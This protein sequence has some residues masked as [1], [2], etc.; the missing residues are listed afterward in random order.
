MVVR[1]EGRLPRFVDEV[2]RV[3]LEVL[4]AVALAVALSEVVEEVRDEVRVAVRDWDWLV[5]ELVDEVV[6]VVVG[7]GVRVS[8]ALRE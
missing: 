6:E 4:V 3:R 2:L 5:L 8:V 7:E 1:R